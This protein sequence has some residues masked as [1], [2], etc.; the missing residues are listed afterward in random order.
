VV[1]RFESAPLHQTH[2]HSFFA[3]SSQPE[4]YSSDDKNFL[5]FPSGKHPRCCP[6]IESHLQLL[7]VLPVERLLDASTSRSS[8]VYSSFRDA[9]PSTTFPDQS[10]GIQWY[11]RGSLIQ[12]I[13]IRRV[14]KSVKFTYCPKCKEVMVKPWYATRNK[15]ARCR[16]DTREIN[17]PRG[18]LT[19]L[20]YALV[21]AVLV[22]IYLNSQTRNA[23]LLYGALG[24]MVVM[25]IVQFKDLSRGTRMAKS[26]IRPT[27]SDEAEFRKK[28]WA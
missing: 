8:R 21:G 10:P 28:G 11:P 13:Y 7:Q 25:M 4:S 20:M 16:G 5:Y 18:P 12:H 3:N 27:K 26:R 6:R 23:L 1:P 9:R 24:A 19:Y 22:L 17:V 2:N 15:C 14:A